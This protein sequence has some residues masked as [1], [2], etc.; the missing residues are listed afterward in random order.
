M[1]AMQGLFGTIAV[2]AR[3]SRKGVERLGGHSPGA[4]AANTFGPGNVAVGVASN[5]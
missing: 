3:G 2:T 1:N 5:H 4:A